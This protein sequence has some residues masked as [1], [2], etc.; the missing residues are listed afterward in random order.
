M[1]HTSRLVLAILLCSSSIL[2]SPTSRLLPRLEAMFRGRRAFVHSPQAAS[3]SGDT[4]IEAL[5]PAADED[6]KEVSG[7]EN[8]A[9]LASP[10]SVSNDNFKI[11]AGYARSESRPPLFLELRHFR[12]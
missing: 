12:C 10:A 9:G 5:D 11:Q 2:V 3:P 6:F 4:A 7:T 1:R 8:G